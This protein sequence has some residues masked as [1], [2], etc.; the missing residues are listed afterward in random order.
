MFLDEKPQG[1]VT[2]TPAKTLKLSEAI[3]IGAQRTKQ[4]RGHYI[5][6][7]RACVYGAAAIGMGGGVELAG[8]L[9]VRSIEENRAFTRVHGRGIMLANDAG[10]SRE[11]IADWLE[12]HGW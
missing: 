6:G 4:C 10:M 5:D 11:Q 7:D 2:V 12:E 1:E 8:L 3:R 9:H